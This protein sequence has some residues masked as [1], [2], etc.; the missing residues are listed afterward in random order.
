MIVL[1]ESK[2]S[3]LVVLPVLYPEMEQVDEISGGPRG[4]A[5]F[6]STEVRR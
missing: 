6:G 3:Q 5:G 1:R 2:I 4:D